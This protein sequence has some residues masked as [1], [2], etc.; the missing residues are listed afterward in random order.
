SQE[1]IYKAAAVAEK[2]F[3]EG[4]SKFG[5]NMLDVK[6]WVRKTMSRYLLRETEREPLIVVTVTQG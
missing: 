6:N 3:I 5:D 4:H 2:A 1:L